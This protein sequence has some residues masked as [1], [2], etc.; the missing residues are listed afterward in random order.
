MRGTHLIRAGENATDQTGQA[1]VEFALVA[2]FIV[3][4]FVSIVQMILLMYAHTTLANSAKEGVRYAIVHGTGNTTCSGPGN[5]SVTPAPVCSPGG[6]ANVKTAVRNFAGLSFQ[7]IIDADVT[8]DYNPSNANGSPCSV[9]GCM[10]RV[11]VHHAYNPFFGLG[12]P[13]YTLNAAANGRIM[14]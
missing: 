5:P 8:V 1:M 11:T 13:T 7:N 14:N 2:V 6:A 4:L 9:P 3:L 10:V 12:W